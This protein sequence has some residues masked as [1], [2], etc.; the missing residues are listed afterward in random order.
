[1]QC[2]ESNDGLLVRLQRGEE[3]QQT[4]RLLTAERGWRGATAQGIGA[5]HGAELGYYLL[6]EQR[7]ERA[8]EPDICE[9]LSCAGNLAVVDG[10]PMWHLHATLMRRDRSVVG[11]HLFAAW[12]AVTA[13]FAIRQTD[14]RLTRRHDPA[15][16]LPLLEED[17]S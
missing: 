15:A 1:M 3:I 5:V 8:L 6:D 16:G 12:V 2:F 9:L 10:E 14:L 17:G 13:E 4:L 11:G 7:Y